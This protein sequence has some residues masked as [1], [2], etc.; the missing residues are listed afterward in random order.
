[1]KGAELPPLKKEGRGGFA[2]AFAIN[3]KSKSKSS[4]TPLFQRGEQHADA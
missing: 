2:F 4:L 3:N 1:M